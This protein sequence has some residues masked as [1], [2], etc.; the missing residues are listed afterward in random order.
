MSQERGKKKSPKIFLGKEREKLS[1]LDKAQINELLSES[2]SGYVSKIT[3]EVKN[4][5]DMVSL[6]N[7]YITEFLEAFLLFGYDVKGTPLCI[8]YARNQKDADALNCLVNK[9]LFNKMN[10]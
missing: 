9:A 4:T 3:K 7:G 6:L 10:E 8:H 5:E 2:I 1:S